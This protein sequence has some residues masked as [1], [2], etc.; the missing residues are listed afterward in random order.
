MRVLAG[1]VFV[2]AVFAGCSYYTQ[3]TEAEA[4]AHSTQHLIA[5]SG[6]IDSVGVLPHARKAPSAATGGSADP[7]AYR[8]FVRMDSG[9]FQTVDTDSSSFMAGE[10][11]EI[12][13]N[14]RVQHVSGTTIQLPR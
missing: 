12:T 2:F 8:L 1:L 4:Q 9:G 14:G 7:N 5:G 10:S 11:I 13:P 6:T 3:P